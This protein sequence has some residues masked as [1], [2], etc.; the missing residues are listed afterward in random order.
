MEERLNKKDLELQYDP[1]S[2]NFIT[3]AVYNP[4]F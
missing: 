1:K 4:E 2:I 3:K